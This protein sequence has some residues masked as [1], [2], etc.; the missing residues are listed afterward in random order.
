MIIAVVTKPATACT[1]ALI[2]AAVW[3]VLHVLSCT[4]LIPSPRMVFLFVSCVS[5]H[6]CLCDT[7]ICSHIPLTILSPLFLMTRSGAMPACAA[8]WDVA[9]FWMFVYLTEIHVPGGVGDNL[10]ACSWHAEQQ[11]QPRLGVH[12]KAALP[13]HPGWTVG[14]VHRPSLWETDGM[15]RRQRDASC[16]RGNSKPQYDPVWRGSGIWGLNVGQHNRSVFFLWETS[17]V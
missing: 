17:T 4:E 1:S 3:A 8:A 15:H 7:L 10:R 6:V 16:R 5:T 11:D 12:E 14:P 9:W 13:E 2:C